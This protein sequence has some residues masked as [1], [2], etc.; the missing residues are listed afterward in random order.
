MKQP[1]TRKQSSDVEINRL[2]ARLIEGQT[3]IAESG[4]PL[5][6]L[7]AGTE[8]VRADALWSLMSWLDP[9]P[10]EVHAFD[11]NDIEKAGRPEFAVWFNAL[12][13]RGEIGLY[14]TGW[15]GLLIE[16]YLE[17]RIDSARVHERVQQLEA[18]EQI[19]RRDGYR[20]LK[21]WL[22]LEKD[23]HLRRLAK[24]EQR[25]ADRWRITKTDRLVAKRYS[26]W[27]EL[28]EA[29]FLSQNK[30][31]GW[32]VINSP[33][34]DQRGIA[35]GEAVARA[36]E[37]DYKPP[38]SY[39]PPRRKIPDR[40]ANADLTKTVGKKEYKK[41]LVAL[42]S[43][44]ATQF[45]IARDLE[46]GVILALEGWDAAG[47]GG[48]IKRVLAA[49]DPRRTRAV[50]VA[51]PTAEELA[52]HYLWRFTRELPEMGEV[53]IF[54]RTWYGRVLVERV[55]AI[56]SADR[57][58]DAYDEI[59]RFESE[60]ADAGYLVL[61]FWL[62]ISDQEQLR[63]FELRQREQHKLYKITEED[64]RNRDKRDDYVTAV[65]EMLDRTDH[66]GGRWYVIPAE[67]KKSARLEVLATIARE[68]EAMHASPAAYRLRI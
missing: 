15:Y 26:R 31:T 20:I 42:T 30:H 39:A 14:F 21:L 44:V 18:F 68:L 9:R 60:L 25:K 27:A 66:E 23:D 7:I 13:P 35:V 50:R 4:V 64:W 53:A 51:A 54:D 48:A 43:R 12:P 6:V 17:G 19:L 33:D 37:A 56:T 67:S 34:N 8:S 32:Q 45:E 59:I 16:D 3:R 24:L 46:R 22:T 58:A 40:L 61:K 1:S 38:A 57:W 65:N 63:R 5:I 10:V 36:L 62:E 41:Q 11:R 49:G 55:E 47:K 29:A 52:H 2:K 28:T